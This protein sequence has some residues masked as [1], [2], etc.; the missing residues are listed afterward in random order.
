MARSTPLALSLAALT[1]LAPLAA[2]QVQLTSASA[3]TRVESPSTAVYAGLYATDGGMVEVRSAR[4]H[5]VVVAHGAEVA[6]ALAPLSTP[7]AATDARAEV[8]LDAWTLDEME[9]VVAAVR[10][11]R[12]A[13]AAAS[14]AAYRAALVRGRGPAVAGS[15]IGTFD[16]TDGRS[17]TLVQMLFER[18]PEWASFVWDEDGALVTIARGLSPVVLGTARPSGDDHFEAADV[19]LAFEREADGRVRALRVGDRFSAVR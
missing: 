6:A 14:F 12:R 10:P 16:Q 4:G 18:G 7:D 2:A 3:E 5:L 13:Q 9:T 17:A 15:V 19:P 11:A 8:L 1:A